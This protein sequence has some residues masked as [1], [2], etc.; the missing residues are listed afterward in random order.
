MASRGTLLV[1]GTSDFHVFRHLLRPHHILVRD[2]DDGDSDERKFHVTVK[3]TRGISN[4]LE[5]LP[6]TI[7]AAEAKNLSIGVVVDANTDVGK[8]WNEIVESCAVPEKPSYAFPERP[9][10]DGTIVPSPDGT[11][12]PRVGVWMMPDNRTEGEIEDFLKF[13]IPTTDDSHQLYENVVASVDSIPPPAR[14]GRKRSKAMVHTW[15]AWQERPGT[16]M[17]LAIKERYLDPDV[18]QADDFVAWVRRLFS[19]PGP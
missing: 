17:G 5:Q 7:L 13:L 19:L 6:A 3:Q 8:R 16:P 11:L 18:K 15:L 12:L 1:E 2:A 9:G 14:F 10:N 4:L